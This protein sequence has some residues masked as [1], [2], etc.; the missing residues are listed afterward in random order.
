MMRRDPYR[1]YRRAMRRGFRSRHGA[2]PILVPRPMS[3]SRPW[4][5]RHW[6]GWPTGTGRHSCRS[7]LPAPRSSSRLSCIKHHPGIWVLVAVVTVAAGIVTG[8][9]HRLLWAMPARKVTAGIITRVWE[10]CG[11]TRPAERAYVTAVVVTGGGWLSAAIA[12]GPLTRPLPAIAGIATVVLGI[13]WW[14]HRRRRAKVRIE[15]TVQT[16]PDMAENMGVP[17]SRIVSATGNAWGFTARVILR[18]G[19]TAAQAIN[20][21]PAIESG[22]G[23]KPGKRPRGS[24]SCPRGRGSFCGLWKPIRTPSRFRGRASRARR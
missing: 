8:V 12:A 11:I 15:R 2:Y 17:G 1:H 22:L 19:M 20:Q 10:A 23:T 5:S 18:K 9:P 4:P 24:R 16:W 14:A 3:R 21:V 6:P 7:L 13:P